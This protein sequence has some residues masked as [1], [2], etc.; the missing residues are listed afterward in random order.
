MADASKIGAAIGVL[1]V[2][3]GLKREEGSAVSS[4][5]KILQS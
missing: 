2:R 5:Y 4:G 1:S 3:T